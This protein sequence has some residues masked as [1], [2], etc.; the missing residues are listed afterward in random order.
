MRSEAW[1]RTNPPMW[2]VKAWQGRGTRLRLPILSGVIS[3]PLL[4]R[5]GRVIERPGYDPQT[6]FFFDPSGTVF[7][8]IPKKPTREDAVAA[9]KLLK[10]L[11]SRWRRQRHG[12]VPASR[13]RQSA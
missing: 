6:G 1:V 3:T 4:L 10:N 2:L 7:P 5:T 8:P 13:Y 11:I 9:L 12:S